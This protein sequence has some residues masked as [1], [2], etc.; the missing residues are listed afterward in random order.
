MESSPSSPSDAGM[1]VLIETIET[2][3]A[4]DVFLHVSRG[5]AKR[6]PCGTLERLDNSSYISQHPR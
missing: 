2:N 4:L 1:H 5:S 3:V 6:R